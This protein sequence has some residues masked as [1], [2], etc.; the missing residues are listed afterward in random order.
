MRLVGQRAG[1]GQRGKGGG[2]LVDGRARAPERAHVLGLLLAP[3]QLRT[4]ILRHHLR[5]RRARAGRTTAGRAAAGGVKRRARARL[6]DEVVREGR[7]LLQ[8]HEDCVAD[9]PGAP[10]VAARARPSARL[11]GLDTELLAGACAGAARQ[12]G[13]EHAGPAAAAPARGGTRSSSDPGGPR[14]RAAAHLSR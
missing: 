1:V 5:T 11:R 14:M 8:A 3:D 4:R 12:A 2:A 6:H 7:E 9:A 13:A 10:R